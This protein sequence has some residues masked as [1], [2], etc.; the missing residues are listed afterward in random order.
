MI[1][2]FDKVDDAGVAIGGEGGL[3][4]VPV[5][6]I[7]RAKAFYVDELGFEEEADTR[8]GQGIRLVRLTPPGSGGALLLATRRSD[9]SP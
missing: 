4:P 9:R 2:L 3:V 8:A 6:D 7:D 1:V 5:T